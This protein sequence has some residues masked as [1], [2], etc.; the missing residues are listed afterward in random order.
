M[1]R[2]EANGKVNTPQRGRSGTASKQVS[3]GR[4][5]TSGQPEKKR[6][7]KKAGSRKTAAYKKSKRRKRLMILMGVILALMSGLILRSCLLTVDISELS[8]PS[9]IQQDFIAQDG[10]SRT[11]REMKRVNDIVIH[12][13][14][15]PGSTAK[16]NRDYFDSSQSRVSAH[17]VVGLKGEVIQC[18]PLDEQ[19]SASN[20]RNPDTISIE[21]CHPDST[22][23]FNDKTYSAVI[24]LTAWL[25]EEF[26]LDEED[27]IRHYDV[28][29]KNCPKY[30]V[31]HPK[32]WEQFK[33]DVKR[34][35]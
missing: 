33:Q 20:D 26:H 12:Y 28:T 13:V 25:C 17:F 34:Q 14:A 23:K 3:A 27:V 24:K 6:G 9:Y 10:H 32:A 22:G 30:Y 15:N 8:Y 19:S 5:R 11:G 31:E 35:L 21:V 29:G 18:I 7:R 2:R 1:V 4:S 16:G